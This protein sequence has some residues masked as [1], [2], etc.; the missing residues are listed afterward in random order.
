MAILTAM[1]IVLHS[2]A[3][4]AWRLPLGGPELEKALQAMWREFR[5]VGGLPGRRPAEGCLLE[6]ALLDE[7]EMA[8]LN[9]SSLGCAGPTNVLAFPAGDPPDPESG[10]PVLGWLALAPGVL[11]REALLYKQ[12]LTAHT[13]RLLA[14]GLA[15]LLGYEH[16]ESMDAAAARAASAAVQALKLYLIDEA[17]RND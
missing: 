3:H 4:S 6:L 12:N 9:K 1:R 14:H 15:H 17:G 13:L 11:R 8:R 10:L 5:R 7:T 2:D 16:G